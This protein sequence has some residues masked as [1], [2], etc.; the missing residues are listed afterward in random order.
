LRELPDIPLSDVPDAYAHLAAQG[1]DT[2]QEALALKPSPLFIDI[3]EVGQRQAREARDD[4]EGVSLIQ[5]GDHTFKS[6]ATGAR[7]GFRWRIADDD[8]LLM[9]ASPKREWTIS[10]R[11]LSA[12]LWEHGLSA[13]RERIFRALRPYTSQASDDCVRVSR[14]D[15]CFDFYSPTFSREFDP[16]IARNVVCHSSAKAEECGSYDLWARNGRG[17][18]LTIGSK[19]GLQVQ[20]YDK[21]KEI[22]DASGKTWLYPVW[23]AGLGFDPW[24]DG[25]NADN[26]GNGNRPRDM[27]RLECRFSGE[28]LKDRNVRRPHELVEGRDRLISEA[29]FSRRLTVPQAG[30]SNRRR[31]PL[32]PIFTMA[33]HARGAEDMLP[34]GR[35]VTGRRDALKDRAEKQIRGA[36]RSATILEFGSYDDLKAKA[37]ASRAALFVTADPQHDRKAA[38]AMD[39]YSDVEDAR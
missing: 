24:C 9:I 12:G 25:G 17:E 2:V 14:A 35:K 37:L 32:H 31:W 34:L 20:L 11:Y 6:H 15:W 33:W 10:A 23:R 7:G 8:V 38:A 29:L 3:L 5:L 36:I 27:W 30:D 18:T 26:A 16:G 28:Y 39:R 4:L 1:W 21:T 19:T 13:L 22:T